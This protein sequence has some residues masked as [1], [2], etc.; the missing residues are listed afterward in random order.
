VLVHERKNPEGPKV[1]LDHFDHASFRHIVDVFAADKSGLRYFVPGYE[2]HGEPLIMGADPSTFEALGDGWYR[3]AGQAY[4]LDADA[5]PARL[6]IVKADMNTFQTLGGAYARDGKG[7]ICQGVRKR[8]IDAGQVVGLG[9]LYAR[10]GDQ[11]LYNG[12]V[13]PKLGQLDVSTARAFHDRLLMDAG[14]YMLVDT[15]YRKPIRGLDV[16]SFRFLNLRFAVDAGRVYALDDVVFA[17]ATSLTALPSNPP[18]CM[19]CVTATVLS[20]FLDH[21]SSSERAKKRV[22]VERY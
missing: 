10:M 15:R 20:A 19:P 14:G 3:D 13:V 16:P 21:R 18:P 1:S 22:S 2:K 4:Y 6:A 7:L 11:V 8:K 12:K 9:R 5:D 17:S